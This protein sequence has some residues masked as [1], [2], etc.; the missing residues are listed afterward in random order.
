VTATGPNTRFP[1]HEQEKCRRMEERG[2]SARKVQEVHLFI[3]DA[4]LPTR[5]NEAI[6]VVFNQSNT[7]SNSC[8]RAI[9]QASNQAAKAKG[10]RGLTFSK[11]LIS[12]CW[13]ALKPQPHHPLQIA[14]LR[15]PPPL[16]G[17]ARWGVLR[18]APAESC[19]ERQRQANWQPRKSRISMARSWP[20][21]GQ[22]QTCGRGVNKGAIR[23]A[24]CLKVITTT[25]LKDRSQA[26][27]TRRC[28]VAD[29]MERV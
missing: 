22:Q 28:A 7:K 25:D 6:V 14:K 19:S 23:R 18:S 10:R 24:G 12:C 2:G 3:S 16:A 15:N 1:V 9:E 8:E 4:G 20:G 26:G 11:H 29:G 21:V 17:F 5:Q 27:R 13:A